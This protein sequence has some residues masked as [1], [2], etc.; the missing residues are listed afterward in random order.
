MLT[1]L[2]WRQGLARFNGMLPGRVTIAWLTWRGRDI[3][4]RSDPEQT[5]TDPVGDGNPRETPISLAARHER[6]LCFPTVHPPSPLSGIKLCLEW[7][8]AASSL[9][10]SGIGEFSYSHEFLAADPGECDN[11]RGTNL[12]RTHNRGIERCAA[13]GTGSSKPWEGRQ[14]LSGL[15]YSLTTDRSDLPGRGSRST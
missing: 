6:L 7:A 12:T 9:F 15:A 14:L 8:H 13:E 3:P 4:T 10:R 2:I 5:R 1:Q 11:P